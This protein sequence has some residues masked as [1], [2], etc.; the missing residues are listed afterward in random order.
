MFQHQAKSSK[1]KFIGA[2]P[3]KEGEIK[4]APADS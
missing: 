2:S 4:E 1:A 3:G